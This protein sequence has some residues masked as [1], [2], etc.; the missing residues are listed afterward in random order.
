M[1]YTLTLPI[2]QRNYDPSALYIRHEIKEFGLV[3]INL[4]DYSSLKQYYKDVTRK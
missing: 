1:Q 3:K 2:T 4:I